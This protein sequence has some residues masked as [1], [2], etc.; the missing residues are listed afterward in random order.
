V[1]Q[2][3][4][5]KIELRQ[6]NG[7]QVLDFGEVGTVVLAGMGGDTIVEILSN[8][9]DKSASFERFVFQP[10]SKPEVLRHHLVSQGWMIKDER[11]VSE[12]GR[13][14]LIIAG[15]PGNSP[16]YLSDLEL[17]IGPLILKSK[18][19]LSRLFMQKYLD[20]YVRIYTDLMKSPLHRNRVLAQGYK[21][22]AKRLEEI[23]Y[24][25]QS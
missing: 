22:L 12:N 8:D 14:F 3:P 18:D 9:W 20:K 5:G 11:L 6:G 21:E 7:L 19:K 25:C 23:L 15:V 17:I 2:I 24:A 1:G 13:I 10:M 16:Y 4:E